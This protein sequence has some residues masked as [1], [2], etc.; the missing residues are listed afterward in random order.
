MTQE[1][2]QFRSNLQLANLTSYESNP[3]DGKTKIIPVEY[4]SEPYK[5]VH[6]TLVQD[7]PITYLKMVQKVLSSDIVPPLSGPETAIRSMFDAIFTKENIGHCYAE[8]AAGAQTAFQDIVSNYLGREDENGWVHFVD[9]TQWNASSEEGRLNRASTTE[10][11]QW[12][13][14]MDTAAYY[15][16]F[17]DI[18]GNPLDGSNEQEY[19]IRFERDE[20]PEASRFWSITSYTSKGVELIPNEVDKYHIASY[21]PGLEYAQDGSLTLY[22][23]ANQPSGVSDA[24][25]LPVSSSNGPFNLMLRIYGVVPNSTIALNTYTP[26]PIV[27][28]T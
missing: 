4:Y 9:I 24:N 1:S 26:P 14:G 2:N 7:A 5:I 17:V 6:D 8:F 21:T 18:M 16:T 15:H 28:G 3:G 12:A 23:S 20:I 13:N 10:Y 19:T 22:I 27:P 11:I 25:W